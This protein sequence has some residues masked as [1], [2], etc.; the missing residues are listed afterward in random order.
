MAQSID[1]LKFTLEGYKLSHI[2]G[3]FIDTGNFWKLSNEVLDRQSPSYF[4][5]QFKFI[6]GGSR[7]RAN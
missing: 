4:I 3:N 5:N 1:S 6:F 7:D 2:N